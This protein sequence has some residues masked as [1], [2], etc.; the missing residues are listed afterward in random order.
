[1]AMPK[2]QEVDAWCH[3]EAIDTGA[4]WQPAL[5]ECSFVYTAQMEDDADRWVEKWVVPVI[6]W[7]LSTRMASAWMAARVRAR[8]HADG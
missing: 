1:M 8:R 7:L 6:D 2:L 4:V 5:A 3:W